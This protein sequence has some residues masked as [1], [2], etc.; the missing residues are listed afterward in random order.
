MRLHTAPASTRPKLSIR[1]ES[2]SR[3]FTTTVAFQDGVQTIY[4]SRVKLDAIMQMLSPGQTC[5]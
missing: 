1:G 2:L 5:P 4:I 3:Q